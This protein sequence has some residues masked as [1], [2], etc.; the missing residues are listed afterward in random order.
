MHP[1]AAPVVLR[2]EKQ[3]VDLMWQVQPAGRMR[4]AQ[5]HEPTLREGLRGYDPFTR[6]PNARVVCIG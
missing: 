5:E 1:Y 4:I 6:F 3:R 2:F